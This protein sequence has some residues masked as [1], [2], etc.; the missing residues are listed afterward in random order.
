MLTLYE[1]VTDA[2]LGAGVGALFIALFALLFAALETGCFFGLR[3]KDREPDKHDGISTITAGML[4]LLGFTL[5]LT[6]SFAQNRF[7]ARRESMLN[8]GNS[9]GTAW[10]RAGLIGGEGG[11]ALRHAIETYT[12]TRLAYTRATDPATAAHQIAITNAQ[13]TAIW[14]QAQ[15]WAQENPTPVAATLIAALNDMI[16]ASLT[17]RVTFESGLPSEVGAMLLAGSILGLGAMGYQLGLDGRRRRALTALLLAMWA[18][19]LTVTAD[20][21]SPRAGLIR[22]NA[23]ALEWTLQ[24]FG[25]S[26]QK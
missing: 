14:N 6:I 10:L 9:I 21:A 13:Q 18:G 7:E 19:G 23:R 2:F 24:G 11:A 4:G 25:P 26:V 3:N 12:Q 15:A 17:Q 5:A 8:E 22:A 1:T 16:D 20:L